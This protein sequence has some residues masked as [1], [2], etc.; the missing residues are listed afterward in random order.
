MGQ[1]RASRGQPS[2]RAGGPPWSR[3]DGLLRRALPEARMNMGFRGRSSG[4]RGTGCEIWDS[5]GDPSLGACPTP[6]PAPGYSGLWGI[7]H[8]GRRKRKTSFLHL[9]AR[10]PLGTLL[11][12]WGGG[13]GGSAVQGTGLARPGQPQP[14]CDQLGGLW[15]KR[16]PLSPGFP[17]AHKSRSLSHQAVCR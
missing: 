15:E 7:Q 6:F 2:A 10:R 14:L 3:G 5:Q 9:Q 13:Q 1:P 4:R 16:S 12:A 11:R 8:L 17:K